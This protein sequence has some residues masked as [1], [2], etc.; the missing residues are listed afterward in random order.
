VTCGPQISHVPYEGEFYTREE[1]LG[2]KPAAVILKVDVF[3]RPTLILA[4]TR[5]EAVKDVVR[6]GCVGEGGQDK[7]QVAR[8]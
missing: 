2:A 7:A 5:K 4:R 8:R 6:G 3:S 1:V